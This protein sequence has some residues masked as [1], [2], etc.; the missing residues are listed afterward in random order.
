MRRFFRSL[1]IS[2]FYRLSVAPALCP[3]QLMLFAYC[4]AALLLFQPWHFGFAVCCFAVNG[5]R[6]CIFICLSFCLAFIVCLLRFP[7]FSPVHLPH[8]LPLSGRGGGLKVFALSYYVWLCCAFALAAVRRQHPLLLR[9][10]LLF[11]LSGSRPCNQCLSFFGV[12][13]LLLAGGGF[14]VFLSF[15]KYCPAAGICHVM[16]GNAFHAVLVRLCPL[17]RFLFLPVLFPFFLAGCPVNTWANIL[18][19]RLLPYTIA[20][21]YC[22]L[23]QQACCQI[24]F[25]IISFLLKTTARLTARSFYGSL[26]LRH[27][28]ACPDAS[29]PS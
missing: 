5:F 14:K 7:L 23:W 13:G 15:I 6:L 1:T 8:A 26:F 21:Y 12:T 28:K 10:P 22:F 25:S 9:L 24:Y 17:T 19:V 2:H 16:S 18:S 20:L 29:L 4:P 27:P 11:F 3:F